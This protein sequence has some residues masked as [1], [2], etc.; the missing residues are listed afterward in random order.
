MKNEI[1]IDSIL[2]L[3]SK[4]NEVKKAG[5]KKDIDGLRYLIGQSIRQYDIPK[6]NYHIS[7]NA[8]KRWEELSDDHIENYW[9]R[10]KVKCNKLQSSKFF[11]FYK[12]LEN[13]G[14]EMELKPGGSFTFRDMFH[15]EHIIPVSLIFDKMIRNISSID[16]TKIKE[17]LDGIHMCI[18]LK[19]EDREITQKLGKT[20]HRTDK[21]EEN[22][23]NIYNKCDIT[24]LPFEQFP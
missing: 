9:Y 3:L 13:K 16:K 4:F 12:G 7:V 17:L 10:K 24:L 22:V 20:A 21:Y 11:K 14:T 8:K 15:E 23:K 1:I 6:A 18:I 2:C 5:C 19:E